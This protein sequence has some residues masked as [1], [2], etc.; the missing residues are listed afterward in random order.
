MLPPGAPAA[1]IVTTYKQAGQQLRAACEKAM[2]SQEGGG[3]RDGVPE[4]D[5][6]AL[7]DGGFGELG[8]KTRAQLEPLLNAPW[9]DLPFSEWRGR[10]ALN[11]SCCDFARIER[12]F[13]AGEVV[14]LDGFLTEDALAELFRLGIESTN[15]N[16]IKAG[17]YLGAFL[18][19]GFAPPVA[20]QLALDL[21]S[22]LPRVFDQQKLL[23]F[24]GFK[25][26]T[27]KTR[28]Y[29]GI[30]AHADTAAV[31]LNFW[32]TPDEANLN[33]ESGGLVV[34]DAFSDVKNYVP[35]L[36][37]NPQPARLPAALRASHSSH[38]PPSRQRDVALYN[39]YATGTSEIGLDESQVKMRVPYRQNRAV[40]FTSTLFHATDTVEFKPGFETCRINYTLLF[41][42]MEA[43]RC[44]R[45][46]PGGMFSRA[47][48]GTHGT[49]LR[50]EL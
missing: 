11:R 1:A 42:F 20:A 18:S 23:M 46:G 41:G 28:R 29:H 22:A 43:A 25:H 38:W 8:R 26:D 37:S 24:W 31:N 47:G 45:A 35:Q 6:L 44:P 49:F 50:D 17:G 19:D 13:L 5:A 34:Y 4:C 2:A 10:A 9:N 48:H 39:N 27:M 36:K 33:P 21:E 14:V 3:Q 7:A 40:L 12:A 30:K 32:V 16:Q 15:W